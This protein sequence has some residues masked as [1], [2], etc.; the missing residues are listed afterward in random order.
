[1]L[2]IILPKG[3]E[4][5]YGALL[6]QKNKDFKVYVS[7]SDLLAADYETKLSLVHGS[8]EDVQEP[9]VCF[10]ESGAAPDDRFVGRI[11]RT[12]GRHPEFDVYH[13]NLSGGRRF[14][15]KANAEKVFKLTVLEEAPAPLSAFVFRTDK[16]REKAVLKADGS[17]DTIPTVLSCAKDT[18]VRNVWLEELQWTA[19]ALSTDPVATEQRIR[20]RLDL[21][22][23]SET[24]FGDENFPLSVGNQLEVFATEVAKLYPSYSPEDLKEIMDGFQVSQGPIRKMRA[25]SALKAAL[26]ARQKALQQV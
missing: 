23:W 16:L 21:L 6:F 22:R 14:P 13:L 9:L 12:A 3:D 15:R 18:P 17:L 1:M 25:S 11:L 26:K 7:D 24:Y 10:L 4:K 20:A 8:L 2:A 5:L 19:P